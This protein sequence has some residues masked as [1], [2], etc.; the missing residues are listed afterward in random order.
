[1]K[2]YNIWNENFHTDELDMMLDMAEEW[3]ENFTTTWLK[4]SNLNNM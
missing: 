2:N 3:S 4:S 1:M